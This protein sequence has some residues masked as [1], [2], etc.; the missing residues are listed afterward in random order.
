MQSL[1]GSILD[2]ISYQQAVKSAFVEKTLNI[3]FLS[4]IELSLSSDRM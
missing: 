3:N 4:E 2:V 1:Y